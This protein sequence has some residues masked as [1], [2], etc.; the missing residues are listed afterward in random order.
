MALDNFTPEIW[1]AQILVNLH[2]MLV[3]GS[4]S[5]VNRDY[6]GE[7]SR[8][9][10]TVRINSVGGVRVSDYVKNTDFSEPRQ[11]LSSAQQALI[12]DQAKMFNFEI[13][14]IDEA[15]NNPTVL[16]ATTREASFALGATQDGFLS[17]LMADALPV[18]STPSG[19][20]LGEREMTLT[21]PSDGPYVAMV[22]MARVL[23]ENNAPTVGRW[24]V[25]SPLIYAELLKDARFTSF[26]TEANRATIGNRAV[27]TVA[28]FTVLVSNRVP[29]EGGNPVVLGG[30]TMATTLADQLSSVEG[31][32][33]EDRFT[34]ALKGL[35]LYGAK[36]VRP[37]LLT[38]YTATF[39]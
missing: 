19:N 33:P 32:R 38:G 37:E 21:G 39:S 20:F 25:V 14:D 23:D 26:G 2:D 16:A 6:Q 4:P 5:V 28:G 9:G 15:Q 8:Y 18:G 30:S 11:V 27:G 1:S 34:D 22:D 10:D 35:H 13:D 12:I 31:Y 24:V 36:V 17:E 3:Y 29:D 7:I